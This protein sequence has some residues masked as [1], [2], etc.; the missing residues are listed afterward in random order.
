MDNAV[1]KYLYSVDSAEWERIVLNL[2]SYAAYLLKRL[3]WHTGA[4]PMGVEAGDLAL[5][6]IEALFDDTRK[7]NPSSNPDL[8]KYLKSVV[9]SKVS[10]LYELKE[11]N[12]TVRDVVTEDGKTVE[13]LRKK[14]DPSDDHA[15]HLIKERLKNPE[16]ILQDKQEN[17]KR[18]RT[19]KMVADSFLE[20]ITGDDEL[21]ELAL[22]IMDIDGPVKPSDIAKQMGKDVEYVYN[23]KKRFRRKCEEFKANNIAK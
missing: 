5:M 1:L 10:H 3:S 4:I 11:Y 2:A 17:K 23:L 21:E 12:I 18:G 16:E 15:V 13:E 19:D 8:L 22:I 14:A 7:W 9:K 6:S 20:A